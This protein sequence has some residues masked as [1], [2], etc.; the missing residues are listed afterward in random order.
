MGFPGLPEESAQDVLAFSAAEP[1][2]AT[3]GSWAFM[4]GA[5]FF[6]WFVARL[7]APL[8]EGR[9]DPA[10]ESRMRLAAGTGIATGVFFVGAE[11]TAVLMLLAFACS[12]G[13]PQRS[14][15]PGGS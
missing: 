13:A 10:T 7:T 3:M 4:L 11:M 9:P 6:V 12:R 2:R 1:D 15:V 8:S 5:V 14:P